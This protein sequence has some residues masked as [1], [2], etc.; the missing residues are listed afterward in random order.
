MQTLRY[1]TRGNADPHGKPRI[2]YTSHPDDFE[3]YFEWTAE[4]LLKYQDAAV[5]YLPEECPPGAQED[6]ADDL[7]YTLALELLEG[8]PDDFEK[9]GALRAEASYEKAKAAM[10][11]K[12]WE[13]AVNL[14]KNL[15]REALRQKR[16]NHSVSGNACP[17]RGNFRQPGYARSLRRASRAY[18]RHITRSLPG[19]RGR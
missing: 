16:R 12:N 3:R 1:K 8:V 13:T 9:A 19:H 14:L 11:Q 17:Q 10:R 2:L 18:A 7:E 15:D 6:A 5:W 4:E